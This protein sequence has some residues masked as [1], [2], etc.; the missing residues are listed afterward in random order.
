MDFLEGVR[1]EE[2]P[3]IVGEGE[4][5]YIES[6][7]SVELPGFEICFLIVLDNGKYVY[8]LDLGYERPL[9]TGRDFWLLTDLLSDNYPVDIYINE[10]FYKPSLPSANPNGP[11]KIDEFID[12]VKTNLRGKY[13]I[14][15]ANI[16]KVPIMVNLGKP[17]SITYKIQRNTQGYIIHALDENNEIILMPNLSAQT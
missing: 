11:S 17:S 5:Y 12:Y 13:K 10:S 2:K 16:S 14:N 6:L 4:F 1:I 8:H 9:D 7:E 3:R 15:I